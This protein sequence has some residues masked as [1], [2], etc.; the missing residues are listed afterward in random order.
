MSRHLAVALTL[1]LASALL[2]QDPRAERAARWREDLAM[3]AEQLPARHIDPFTVLSRREFDARVKQLDARLSEL[4]D[5]T[6]QF[7]LAR[8]V[9]ALGDSHTALQADELY[10]GGTLPFGFLA[11]RDGVWCLLAPSKKAACAGQRLVKVGGRDLVELRRLAATLF[12]FDNESSWKAR[13]GSLVTA[14]AR[15]GEK[16]Y[17]GRADLR[18]PRWH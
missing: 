5:L 2:A 13:V 3:L 15:A 10:Q 8:L 18:R 4:D 16:R 12:V 17:G 1:F 9:A 7:E 11:L 14:Y 6:T